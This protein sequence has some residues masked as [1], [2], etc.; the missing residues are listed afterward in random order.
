MIATIP[1]FTH[2][3]EVLVQFLDDEP[4]E[5]GRRRFCAMWLA[6]N[7]GHAVNESG[8]RGQVFFT[9]VAEFVAR[10]IRDGQTVRSMDGA[11]AGDTEPTHYCPACDIH[12]WADT[13]KY[14][15]CPVCLIEEASP[16]R[17]CADCE[18]PDCGYHAA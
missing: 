2:P 1:D 15:A 5:Q 10:T 14:L 7:T 13:D 18:R 11:L 16:I 12:I 3:N 6:D 8:V 9:N 4:D 17:Y